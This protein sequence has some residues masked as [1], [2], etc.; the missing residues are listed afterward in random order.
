V[1][2]LFGIVSFIAVWLKIELGRVVAPANGES[3]FPWE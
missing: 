1:D 2:F 3:H